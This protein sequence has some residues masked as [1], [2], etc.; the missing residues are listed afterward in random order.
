MVAM[1]VEDIIC[2]LRDQRGAW[3]QLDAPAADGEVTHVYLCRD[4]P[5]A[6]VQ[7][8]VLRK[9]SLSAQRTTCPDCCGTLRCSSGWAS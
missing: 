9:S 3:R 7:A 4:R 5:R 6:Q 8:E 1:W 2:A